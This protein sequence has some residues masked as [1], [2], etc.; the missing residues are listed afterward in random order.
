MVSLNLLTRVDTRWLAI[1][2]GLLASAAS[3]GLAQDEAG[4]VKA[5][6]ALLDSFHARAPE[7]SQRKLHVIYFTPLD[8]EPAPDW[9]PRVQRVMEHCAT[10]MRA[11]WNASASD[12]APWRS[13]M[14]RTRN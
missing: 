7:A 13:T 5:A 12:G 11:R 8:R 1:A 9:Q 4:Q 6:R 14:A 3:R 10:S 2:L